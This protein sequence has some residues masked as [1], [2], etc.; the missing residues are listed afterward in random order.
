MTRPIS[1]DQGF[2][3]TLAL[4]RDPYGHPFQGL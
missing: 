1:R 4:I 3:A 2:G